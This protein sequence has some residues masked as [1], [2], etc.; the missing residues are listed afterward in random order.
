MIRRALLTGAGNPQV[1]IRT[2][3]QGVGLVV[4][5]SAYEREVSILSSP[6]NCPLNSVHLVRH[7]DTDNRLLLRLGTVSALNLEDFPI[8]YW[9]PETITNSIVPFACP[10]SIDPVCLTGVDYSDVLISVKSRSLS[11]VPHTIPVHGFSGLGAIA[12]VMVVRSKSLPPDP[13]FPVDWDDDSFG[14]GGDDDH[15]GDGGGDFPAG[16]ESGLAPPP[17]P[18]S[19][20]HHPDRVV[21]LP[22]GMT[23]MANHRPLVVVEPLDA[24]P[25]AVEVKLFA[26]F[27]DIRVSGRNGECGFYRIPMQP[28]GSPRLL[29]A[30]LASCSIGYL[31]KVATV[32]DKRKPLTDVDVICHDS[33]GRSLGK[34][35]SDDI[36]VMR[37][38]ERFDSGEAL[39]QLGKAAPPLLLLPSPPTVIVASPAPADD[40]AAMEPPAL[41]LRGK[42]PCVYTMRSARLRSSEQ[43]TRLSMLEKATLL[44]KQRL[45]GKPS[46]SSTS[47]LPADELLQL[48]AEGSPPLDRMKVM[49]FAGACGISEIDLNNVEPECFDV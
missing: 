14:G 36:E 13:S 25:V 5:G 21:Q 34:V 15:F 40:V 26:G 12:S 30:N 16:M 9:F 45:N 17:P 35:V 48:A 1:A 47:L 22:G 28:A 11:D 23:M 7:D 8:E 39:S 33:R 43:A 46:A 2:S 31:N 29:V 19:D 3:S 44:K 18:P 10:I 4:F 32:G 6:F 37:V 24:R 42:A 49:Q 38:L 41:S 27:Y 20:L